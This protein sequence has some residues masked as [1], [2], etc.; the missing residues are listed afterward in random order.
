MH[1]RGAGSQPDVVRVVD[2]HVQ[3]EPDELAEL[4]V[5]AAQLLRAQ[6]HHPQAPDAVLA[7]PLAGAG[8]GAEPG[9]RHVPRHDPAAA[10]RAAVGRPGQGQEPEEVQEQGPA[11]DQAYQIPRVQ[12]SSEC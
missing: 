11:E 9:P 6:P 12:G 3:P 5:V 2:V 8:S 7:V 1:T 10:G 4:G